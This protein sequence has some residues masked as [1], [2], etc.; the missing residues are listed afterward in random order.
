MRDSTYSAHH[1][2]DGGSMMADYEDRS[3]LDRDGGDKVGDEGSYGSDRGR[4]ADGEGSHGK[5]NERGLS[6][7]N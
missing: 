1:A 2:D 7:I 5:L 4:S 6:A 3:N